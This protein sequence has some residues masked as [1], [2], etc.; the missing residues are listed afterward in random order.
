MIRNTAAAVSA[1]AL[2]V[3]LVGC[4]SRDAP[5]ATP[6]APSTVGTVAPPA[7]IPAPTGKPVLT[8]TGAVTNH[9]DGSAVLFDVGTLDQAASVTTQ[10]YDPFAKKDVSFT[11][12]PMADLLARVGVAA[13]ATTVHL[14]ALDDYKIELKAI[15]L[16]DRG[17]LLATK[18]DGARIAVSDGGPI[19]LVFPANS[20]VGKNQ[21]LWIWSVDS[22]NVD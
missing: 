19:R 14:H 12:V 5:E 9:N 20:T 16:A 1:L 21:D 15:D 13:G 22:I 6:T 2:A 7:P 8:I 17:I 11:G 18:V 3:A 10:M 4:G